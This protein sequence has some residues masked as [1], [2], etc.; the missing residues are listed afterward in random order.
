MFADEQRATT[1]GFLARAVGWFYEQGISC[2]RVLSDNGPAYRFCDWR[3][4]CQA[5]DLKPIST[6]PYTPQTNGKA[7]RFIKTLLGEWAYV[8]AYKASK[9]RNLW[10][11]G[12]LEM[13]NSHS[14]HMAL[15]GLTPQQR[16]QRL[17]WGE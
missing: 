7:E 14:C 6:K 11:P 12:S 10:L 3:K 17:L 2:R 9:E 13:Y 5:L 16:L 1:L 8:M 15:G 4:A